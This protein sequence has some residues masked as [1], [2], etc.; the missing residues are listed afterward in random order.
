[1]LNY[2]NERENTLN[3]FYLGIERLETMTRK[4]YKRIAAAIREAK[5]LTNNA[6]GAAYGITATQNKIAKM[7]EEEN[8]RFNSE[9][10][11][12]ACKS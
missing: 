9:I 8:P 10:F 11:Q 3:R 7:L 12:Q 1:M 6:I 2:R 5:L 4:D